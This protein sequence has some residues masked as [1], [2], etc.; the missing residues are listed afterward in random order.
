MKP[1]RLIGWATDDPNDPFQLDEDG[2]PF[3]KTLDVALKCLRIHRLTVED[4]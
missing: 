2:R 3:D 4:E 1:D